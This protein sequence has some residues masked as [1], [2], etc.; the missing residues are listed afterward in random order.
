MGTTPWHP[1]LLRPSLFAF[2]WQASVWGGLLALIW[3]ISRMH[4]PGDVQ[5]GALLTL[6]ALALVAE[7]RPVVVPGNDPYG[8]VVSDAFVFAILYLYG[9]GP[10]IVTQVIVTLCSEVARRKPLWKVLFNLGQYTISLAAAWSVMIVFGETPTL[11][12]RLPSIDGG[13]L[14]WI[15]LTWIVYFLVNNI[16]VSGVSGDEGMSFREAFFEDFWYYVL[17]HFAVFVLSPV[18]ALVAIGPWQLLPLFLLPLFAVYKAAAISREKD[19]AAMHDALTEL[20]NRTLLI[21]RLGDAIETARRDGSRVGVLLLDLNRFK[22]VND[23][24]GH[25]TGD[26]LLTI[27]ASRIRA[28]VRPDDTVARLGGDEFTVVLPGLNDDLLAVEV[29]GRVRVAITE[30]FVIDDAL[31]DIDVSVGIAVFPDHGDDVET[32]LRHADVAMY[33]AKEHSTS[34]EFFRTERETDN[35]RLGMLG[36]LRRAL[37]DGGIEVHFQPVVGLVHDD[38]IGM[39]AFARW[40][41]PER[42]LLLPGTFL[43]VAE[44]SGLMHRLTR[45]VL[46][47]ALEQAAMWHSAGF[48]VPVAVNIAL[49]DLHGMSLAETVERGLSQWGLPG[50]RLK[51]EVTESV[52]MADPTRVFDSIDALAE[53][54]V[55]LSL[56]D[57]G[58]GFASMVMLRRLPVDEVKIDGAF[59]NRIT[60]SDDDA[61]IVNS[62]VGLSHAL[63]LRSVAEGVENEEV[64][65]TLG[66]MGCDAAQGWA[67]APVMMADE[68]LNWLRTR[69]VRADRDIPQQAGRLRLV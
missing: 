57:F 46:D 38:V 40:R 39:E 16:L 11:T 23:T 50:S 69:E 27:A 55:R 9:V 56:D 21:E 18:I 58:T 67:I 44:S 3:A 31:I 41:H 36:G 14:G 2:T 59:V 49:R 32:L 53:L 28:A 47:D 25:A 34:I 48:D 30:P 60:T 1:S 7:L 4:V 63:G 61:A 24:M 22:E 15:S 19:H 13:D 64:R 65:A 45:T 26:R 33:L 66:T 5:I 68:A 17:T 43:P 29:A 52:F 20:P 54:G 37:D 6:V 62:I 12:T 35:S 51:L 42:G 10:A 8:V